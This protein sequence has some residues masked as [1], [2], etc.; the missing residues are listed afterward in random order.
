MRF[1]S[2]VRLKTSGL[3]VNA[4]SLDSF[5]ARSWDKVGVMAIGECT[6]DRRVV[7]EVVQPRVLSQQLL[8]DS[9]RLLDGRRADYVEGNYVQRALRGITQRSQFG[10]S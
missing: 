6:H 3:N 10:C 2:I 9:H 7:V 5:C 1:D 4:E 8:H